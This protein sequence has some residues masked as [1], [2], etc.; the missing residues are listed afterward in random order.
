M[1]I[2]SVFVFYYH[3]QNKTNHE[4]EKQKITECLCLHH[5]DIPENTLFCSHV[6]DRKKEDN[7]Y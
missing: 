7:C 5:Y 4:Q 3:L 6:T 2:S 1:I